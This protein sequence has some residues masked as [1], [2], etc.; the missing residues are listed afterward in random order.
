VENLDE[1]ARVGLLAVVGDEFAAP[2]LS[3]DHPGPVVAHG[4]GTGHWLAGLTILG[5]GCSDRS[6]QR[7]SVNRLSQAA[8]PALG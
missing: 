4:L 3:G 7:R 5:E 1:P 6:A 8:S 2:V